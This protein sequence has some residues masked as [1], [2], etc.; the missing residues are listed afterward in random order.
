MGHSRPY[1][2]SK[3]LVYLI[4]HYNVVHLNMPDRLSGRESRRREWCKPCVILVWSL[5]ISALIRALASH[6]RP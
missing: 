2:G 1:P 4:K 3:S 6:D 5:K